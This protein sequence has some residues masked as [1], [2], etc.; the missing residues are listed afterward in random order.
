MQAAACR[1]SNGLYVP[2]ALFFSLPIIRFYSKEGR[3]SLNLLEIKNGGKHRR[4][5]WGIQEGT[6]EEKSRSV[7]PLLCDPGWFRGTEKYAAKCNL[8][9]TLQSEAHVAP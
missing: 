9:N 6:K 7:R 4:R 8:L 3:D 5:N 1:T 2:L